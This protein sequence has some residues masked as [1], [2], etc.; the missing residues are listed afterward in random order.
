[1]SDGTTEQHAE[2]AG[3]RS[4]GARAGS[5]LLAIALLALVLFAFVHVFAPVIGPDDQSPPGHP[6]SACIACHIVTS[7]TGTDRP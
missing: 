3:I 1:M 7:S 6:Q 5:W 2:E 4:V